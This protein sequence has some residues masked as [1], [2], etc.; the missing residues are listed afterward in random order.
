MTPL[1]FFLI[2]SH[3]DKYKNASHVQHI[4]SRNLAFRLRS[5]ESTSNITLNSIFDLAASCTSHVNNDKIPTNE[6]TN[7][8]PTTS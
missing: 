7:Y 4:E 2:D 5:E 1:V 6:L 8:I 3:T